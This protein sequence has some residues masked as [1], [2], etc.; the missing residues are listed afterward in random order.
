MAQAVIRLSVI[1]KAEVRFRFNLCGIRG[2]LSGIGKGF[3]SRTSVFHSFLLRNVSYSYRCAPLSDFRS[4][5]DRIYDGV[6]I[7]L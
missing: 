1:A 4:T 6:P 5:T 7:I 3:A 2:G